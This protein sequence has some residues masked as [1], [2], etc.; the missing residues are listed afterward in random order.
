MATA[1]HTLVIGG[2][3]GGLSLARELTLRGLRVTVREKAA[4]LSVESGRS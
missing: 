2:G 4:K 1:L 3:S